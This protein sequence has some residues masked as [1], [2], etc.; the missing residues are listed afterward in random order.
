MCRSRGSAC[1]ARTSFLL[2]SFKVHLTIYKWNDSVRDTNIFWCEW[3]LY[4]AMSKSRTIAEA[5]SRRRWPGFEPSSGHV[6]FVV[7]KVALG[8]VFSEYFGFPCQFSFQRLLHIH[9]HHL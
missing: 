9:H 8:Q 5:V 7:D 4:L 1:S 3:L 2:Y 6:G